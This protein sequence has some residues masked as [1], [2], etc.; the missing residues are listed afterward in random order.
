VIKAVIFDL[1]GTLVNLPINYSELFQEF[2]R[3]AG[4]PKVQPITRLL[5]EVNTKTRTAIFEVWDRAELVAWEKATIIQEGARLYKKYLKKP[6]V[7][8]TM[9]GRAITE[10]ITKELNLSFIWVITREDSYDR[11]QQLQIAIHKL[12]TP[13]RQILFVG[14]TDGDSEAAKAVGCRFLRVKI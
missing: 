1:D 8:I 2:S 12:N 11:I 7:L 3:I 10:L 5:S 4:I 9:Q 13:S 14:N 6:R